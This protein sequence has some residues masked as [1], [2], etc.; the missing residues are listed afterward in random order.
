[1][2]TAPG[3]PTGGRSSSTRRSSSHTGT[4]V[5][6]P[7]RTAITPLRVITSS[8]RWLEIRARFAFKPIWEMPSEAWA[9]SILRLRP[10]DAHLRSRRTAPRRKTSARCLRGSGATSRQPPRSPTPSRSTRRHM[11]PCSVVR[12]ASI[13]WVRARARRYCVSPQTPRPSIVAPYLSVSGSRDAV[14]SSPS[15]S[16]SRDSA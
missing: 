6:S 5:R 9:P 4:S 14:T 8:K 16:S 7:R 3:E 2:A 11:L 10:T 13:H 15:Q 12:C 1:M